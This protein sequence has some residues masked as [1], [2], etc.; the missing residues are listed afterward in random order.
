MV[1][2]RT[3]GLAVGLQSLHFA[4]EAAMGFHQHFPAIFGLPEMPFGAFAVFN[5]AWIV[6]WIFAVAGVRS[7]N[8]AAFFAAWFLAIGGL[9]N[10][11]AHPLLALAV[12]GYFPGLFTSPLIGGAGI[13]LWRHLK[14]ATRSG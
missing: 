11:V 12:G 3:L 1:A 4:E 5:I 13:V 7:L 10:L 8:T 6:A 9:L 2:A 14:R